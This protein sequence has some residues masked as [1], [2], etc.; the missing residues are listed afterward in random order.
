M[1]HIIGYTYTAAHHC[2]D[3][4]L[5]DAACGIIKRVPPLSM[6]TDEHGMTDDL[7]DR[8]GN[9]VTPLFSTDEMPDYTVACDDC[10]AIIWEREE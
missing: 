9:T 8:E 3:C 5:N 1:P 10:H 2:P 4:A 7:I 6:R